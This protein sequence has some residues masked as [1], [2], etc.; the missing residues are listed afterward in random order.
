MSDELNLRI[1]KLMD[2]RG[3]KPYPFAMS[4]GVKSSTM[5][6]I[7]KGRVIFENIS[8]TT[9]LK[10]AHGLGMT[11]EELYYGEDAAT[12]GESC[13]PPITADEQVLLDGYRVADDKSRERFIDDAKRELR[14]AE[15]DAIKKES[16]I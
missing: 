1:A 12:R 15:E 5:T 4:I 11:A 10:I 8:I 9:F 2:E 6:S 16:A 3:L 13:Q 7:Y 14:Y